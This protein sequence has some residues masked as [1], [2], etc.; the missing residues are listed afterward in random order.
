[1]NEYMAKA[2]DKEGKN[3]SMKLTTVN[4]KEWFKSMGA[5]LREWV[6]THKDLKPDT[7]TPEYKESIND[8]GV[9]K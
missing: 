4:Q 6:E 1:V 3:A 5:Y 9:W 2:A 7:W 8:Q